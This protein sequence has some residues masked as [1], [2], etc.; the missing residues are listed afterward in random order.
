MSYAI[1]I[2]GHF[3][4]TIVLVLLSIEA[5]YR[6]GLIVHRRSKREKESPVSSIEGSVLAL[7]AFILALTFGTTSNRFDESYVLSRLPLSV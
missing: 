7:L 6:V 4:G 2:A 3:G 1:P 5:G